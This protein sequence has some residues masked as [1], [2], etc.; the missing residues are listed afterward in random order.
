M[1]TDRI[2]TICGCMSVWKPGY[3]S[4]AKSTG[5]GLSGPVSSIQS[6]PVM[7]TQPAASSLRSS[8]R[9]WSGTQRVVRTVP[10]VTAAATR[11]VPASSR[12]GIT[13]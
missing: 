3:G 7:T 6:S 9:R 13:R 12:S 5:P 11:Y 10:P 8:M 4:V 1:A 2:A